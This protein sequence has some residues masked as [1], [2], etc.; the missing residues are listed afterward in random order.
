MSMDMVPSNK[1]VSN[2]WAHN[3]LCR[4]NT[5]SRFSSAQQGEPQAVGKRCES[6]ERK[7]SFEW[8]VGDGSIAAWPQGPALST[9]EAYG[10]ERLT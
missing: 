6:G 7:V 8:D 10:N 5:Q 2:P 4:C 1:A 3:L 9:E